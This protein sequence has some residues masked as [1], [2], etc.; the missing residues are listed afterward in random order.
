[1]TSAPQRRWPQFSLRSLLWI[2]TEAALILGWAKIV[3][4]GRPFPIGLGEWMGLALLLIMTS[5]L[6]A[7]PL[8]KKT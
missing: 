1:M 8:A 6:W 3:K 7:W 4:W 2:V 5:A